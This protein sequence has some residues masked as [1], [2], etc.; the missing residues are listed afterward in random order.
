MEHPRLAVIGEQVTAK[1]L[2]GVFELVGFQQVD[3]ERRAVL[4]RPGDVWLA[5]PSTLAPHE[6]GTPSPTGWATVRPGKAS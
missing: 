1:G 2:P 6:P 3:D 5:P 4:V